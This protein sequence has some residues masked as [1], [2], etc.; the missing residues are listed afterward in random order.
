MRATEGDKPRKR[1]CRAAKKRQRWAALL[2]SR[3]R[4]LAGRPRVRARVCVRESPLSRISWANSR[5]S[6]LAVA[7]GGREVEWKERE[8]RRRFF[9]TTTRHPKKL[10][11]E[12]RSSRKLPILRFFLTGLALAEHKFRSILRRSFRRGTSNRARRQRISLADEANRF[13]LSKD[14]CP[15][16]SSSKQ[17]TSTRSDVEEV[18]TRYTL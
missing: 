16:F 8:L 9:E 7:R 10:T 3:E 14:G 6:S 13:S 15:A 17:P 4:R 12:E 5:V 1:D 2:F 18:G 11:A